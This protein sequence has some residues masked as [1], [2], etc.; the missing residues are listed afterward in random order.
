M[1]PSM[2]APGGW[3]DGAA[4]EHRWQRRVA[5]TTGLLFAGIVLAGSSSRPA[6][7]QA[8]EFGVA[9]GL[10]LPAAAY[11]FHATRTVGP[12]IRGT[13]TLREPTRR[14]RFRGEIESAWFFA[15]GA[16][17]ASSSGLGPDMPN[18]HLHAL[19]GLG[20]IMIGGTHPR[21]APYLIAGAGP[22]LLHVEDARNPDGVTFGARAGVGVR[23]RHGRTAL[24]AEVTPHWAFSDFA[25]SSRYNG[26]LYIPVVV[27]ISF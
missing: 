21:F 12:V 20:S 11:S 5:R 14:I 7:G 15:F 24:H 16:V 10:A 2:M 27:G 25:M 23:G 18:G 9:A 3:H 4:R 1:F 19:S 13:L 17:S 8:T 26:G 22:Q 6:V